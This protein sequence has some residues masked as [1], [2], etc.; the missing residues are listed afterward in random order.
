MTLELGLL[1]FVFNF[2]FVLIGGLII[3]WVI[4]NNNKK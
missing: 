2:I 1:A 3:W 4:N